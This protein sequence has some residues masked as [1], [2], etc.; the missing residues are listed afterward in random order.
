MDQGGGMGTRHALTYVYGHTPFWVHFSHLLP[1]VP[2]PMGLFGPLLLSPHDWEQRIWLHFHSPSFPS[3]PVG[4][5]APGQHLSCDT[6]CH[7]G[8]GAPEAVTRIAAL[9][10]SFPFALPLLH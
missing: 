2:V 4:A 9:N 10:H 6:F 8:A 3:P 1:H 5:C 7:S